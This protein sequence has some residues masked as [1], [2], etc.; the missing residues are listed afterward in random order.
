MN[1][2]YTI[3]MLNENSVSV[4]TQQFTSIEGLEYDIGQP[5]R[6]SYVNSIRGRQEVVNQL[7][8]AQQNAIF[9]VWGDIPTVDESIAQ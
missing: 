2:K 8:Q 4:K 1:I 6:K 5:H 7:P 3:D 9:S